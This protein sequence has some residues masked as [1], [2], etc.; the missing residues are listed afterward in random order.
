MYKIVFVCL[1]NLYRSIYAEDRF[2]ELASDLDVDVSSTGLLKLESNKK[3]HLKRIQ[4]ADLI[5]TME[6]NQTDFIKNLTSAPTFTLREYTFGD[7]KD[8]EIVDPIGGGN[9][10]YKQD[11]DECLQIL[12]E[13]IK[14][15]LK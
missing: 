10:H 9:P 12:L 6:Q 5:L 7:K 13:K 4:D 11:I 3:D 2:K 14:Q 8:I 15:E 1:G